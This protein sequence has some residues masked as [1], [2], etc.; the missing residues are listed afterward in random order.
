LRVH[1]HSRELDLTVPRPGSNISTASIALAVSIGMM[2]AQSAVAQQPKDEAP[3]P[4]VFDV[5]AIHPHIPEPHEHNSIASSP[6]DGQF[7][8]ENVTLIMLIHWAYGMPDTRI[9][10]APGWASSTYFNLDAEA[11]PALDQQ[12]RSLSSDAARNLKERM[13]QALLA[14]RFK[15]AIHTETRGLPIYNLVVAKGGP[16]LGPVQESGSFVNTW[17]SRIDLQMSNS[18]SVLAEELSKIVGRDVVDK[19]GITGRYHLKLKWTPDNALEDS[20]PSIFTALEEQ[21]GLKLEPAKGPVQ[22]LVIDHA[23]MPTAN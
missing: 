14:D 8:A 19:T 9:L 20:G 10:S 4:P 2:C 11:D 3:A 6:S 22:V 15:L 21:L 17:N 18:V 23:E 12:L 1:V 13:V 5:A 7:K 16:K